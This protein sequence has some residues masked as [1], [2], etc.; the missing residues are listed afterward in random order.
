MGRPIGSCGGDR[1]LGGSG[2][3]GRRRTA[4]SRKEGRAEA[5]EQKAE[6]YATPAPTEAEEQ[7]DAG[8][9]GHHSNCPRR[10]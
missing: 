8:K 3:I 4:A 9:P 7:H 2:D 6:R 1:D 10:G 5:E